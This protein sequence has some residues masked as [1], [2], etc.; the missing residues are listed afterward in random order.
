LNK[1]DI[2][3][4]KNKSKQLEYTFL[5]SSPKLEGIINSCSKLELNKNEFPFIQEPKNLTVP[6]K[7]NFYVNN[8]ILG[9]NSEEDEQPYLILFVIGGVSHNEICALENL[10]QQ[11]ALNHHLIIGST[12]IMTANQYIEQ[13]RDLSSPV[14]ITGSI[15]GKTEKCV[16]ITDIELGLIKK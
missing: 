5:R 7:K 2:K 13:L 10:Y 3:K 14:D 9:N 12:S 6:K 4:F 15:D 8:E 11:K 1:S 16:D